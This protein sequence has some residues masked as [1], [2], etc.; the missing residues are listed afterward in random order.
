MTRTVAVGKPDDFKRNPPPTLEAQQA[1]I[2]EA[3]HENDVTWF[4]P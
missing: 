1:A 3:A 2:D 4:V